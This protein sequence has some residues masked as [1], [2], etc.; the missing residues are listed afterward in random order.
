MASPATLDT[1]LAEMAQ[2]KEVLNGWDAVMN[3]LESAINTFF[4]SQFRKQTGNTG[5]MTI[6]QVFCG[7]R[8]PSP[9]GDYSVVTSFSFTL[10]PPSFVFTDASNTVTMTQAIVGGTTCTGSLAVEAG[11]QPA[12]CG[13]TAND[14][15]VVWG[16]PERVDLGPHPTVSAKVPLTS[17]TGLIDTRTQTVVLDFANGAFTVANLTIANVG[18]DDIAL[19]IKNWFVSNGVRY[20]LA[21]VVLGTGSLPS[22]T[23]TWFRFRVIK[24]NVGNTIVQLLIHT[25]GTGTQGDPMVPEP[26]PT[27][28]GY[29]CSLMISS[30]ITFSDI[31]CAG[32]N[33]ANKPFRLYPQ[34]TS[35]T[36]GYTATIAP[37]MHFA[38][39]F[40]YGSCCSPTTVT[41]SLYLG[42]TYSG[43]ATHGFH[44]WQEI[45]PSGN[46]GNT[47]TV[48]GDNPV[49]LSG[50]GAAQAICITPLPPTVVVTGGASE[51]IN[52][53]LQEILNT[54]FKTAMAG[55]SFGPVTYFSLRTLLFPD[56]MM[57]MG[58]V[59][60]PTDL[61]IVGTFQPA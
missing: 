40:S 61:V 17:V 48:S 19:H 1:L 31:L 42:G 15:R 38:G 45:T 21:S 33:A 16:S 55:I 43:T 47:I 35:L 3:V 51:T 8:L 30:R 2:N 39:S 52:S 59:Q 41:Y 23:P 10:G 26:I 37:P 57:K 4:Q 53:T 28:D 46:V 56:S 6:S 36:A 29:T 32:F 11:F 5:T 7:P 12:S 24:T 18:S 50:T 14:P 58:V 20:T 44:L 9:H 34:S 25:T 60:V 27:A 49:S 54:D 13:C 22:L